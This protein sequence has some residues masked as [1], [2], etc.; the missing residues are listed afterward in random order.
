MNSQGRNL[1]G[2]LGNLYVLVTVF[3]DRHLLLLYSNVT[4]LIENLEV[5]V[6]G[7][8]RRST[9]PGDPQQKQCDVTR[10]G[11]VVAVEEK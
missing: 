7:P 8:K 11:V 10:A 3:P 2:D 6:E 1:S 4:V 9:Y 5:D